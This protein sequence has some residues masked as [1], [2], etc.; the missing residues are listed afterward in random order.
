MGKI[1][2][3]RHE[4]GITFVALV[5]TIVTLL[6]LAGVSISLI[7]GNNSLFDKAKSTQK[8]QTIAGIKEALELE[9][10]DIQ[11]ESKT[12]YL[13]VFDKL[14]LNDKL[15]P[16]LTIDDLHLNGAGYRI[17]VYTLRDLFLTDR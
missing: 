10:V 16:D 14:L 11:V 15:N 12:V 8:V 5:V 6:I 4:K 9:K 1:R 17:L 7:I 2:E 13:D 3:K